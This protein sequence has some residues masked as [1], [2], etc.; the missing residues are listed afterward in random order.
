MLYGPRWDLYC[1]QKRLPLK[2]K[3]RH[4]SAKILKKMK[5]SAKFERG[6]PVRLKTHFRLLGPIIG[7]RK[8]RIRIVI[9][10]FRDMGG[11]FKRRGS[12]LLFQ[13]G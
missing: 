9:C 11:T 3:N 6:F 12:R 13:S 5:F 2:L 8:L 10:K 7:G 4:G 1:S